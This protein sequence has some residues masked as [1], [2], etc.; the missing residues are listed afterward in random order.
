MPT[1]L[2]DVSGIGSATAEIFKNNGIRS[3]EDLASA[4]IK[5]VLAIPGFGESRAAEVIAAAKMIVVDLEDVNSAQP[6]VRAPVEQKEETAETE[7]KTKKKK[8]S[9]KSKSGKKLKKKNKKRAK[10]KKKK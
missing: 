6:A 5:D 4:D 8:K 3:V 1:D 7:I 2:T 10:G 9:E